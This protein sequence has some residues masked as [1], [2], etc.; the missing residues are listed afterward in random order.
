MFTGLPTARA[1]DLLVHASVEILGYTILTLA[2][3]IILFC[4]CY[5][6]CIRKIWKFLKLRMQ[7]TN[8]PTFNIENEVMQLGSPVKPKRKSQKTTGSTKVNE[9]PTSLML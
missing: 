4:T 6:L 7:T 9:R 8:P 5:H 3:F 2:L 1:D